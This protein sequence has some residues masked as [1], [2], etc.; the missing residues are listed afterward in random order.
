[1]NK[2]GRYE[3]ELPDFFPMLPESL[4]HHIL[5]FLPYKDIVRTS[6]L[7]KMWSR[8]WFNYPNIDLFLHEETYMYTPHRLS[9]TDHIKSVMDQCILRKV[10]IQKLQLKVCA[11]NPEEL[12]PTIDQYLR[13]A[14]ERNVSELVIEMNFRPTTYY[15]IP[16]EVFLSN[17]LKVLEL[18]GCKFEDSVSCTNLP[19]LQRLK[20][21]Q[22]LFA[23]E[24]FL[25]KIL[26]GCPEL[27]YLEVLISEGMRSFLSVSCKPRLKY[28]HIGCG[29]ELKRIEMFVPSLET[30]KCN[31]AYSCSIDL[32][33]CT[34]LKH[35]EIDQAILSSDCVPIQYLL[36]NLLQIEELHLSNCKSADKIQISS[37]CLKRL[38][39]TELLESFPGAE[40]DIPNLLSLNFV[41]MGECNPNNRFSS[42]NVPKVEDIHMLFSVKSFQSACR[43][44]LK[45]F[46]MQLPNYEDLKL[47]IR[48]RGNQVKCHYVFTSH[49]LLPE[50]AYVFLLRLQAFYFF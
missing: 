4:T 9:F 12:A 39:M 35:L 2:T 47:I 43:G 18:Q 50:V 30:L 10:C 1:M 16:K 25:S 44:G 13:A 3:N 28:F 38:V 32:A 31:F 34:L 22:C 23:G 46:L 29:N 45:G 24:N 42:W 15:N 48:C 27:E 33:S 36:S 21:M 26:C 6:I 49:T 5:S 40:L 17:S 20:T 11:G 19:R 8:I 7:S 37:S 41:S 14:I